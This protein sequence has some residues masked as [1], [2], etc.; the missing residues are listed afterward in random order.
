LPL[1]AFA[2]G[3]GH[4]RI[5]RDGAA[6]VLEIAA[7]CQHVSVAVNDPGFRRMQRADAF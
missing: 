3:A 4:R 7:Q 5:E 2:L 1:P 6:G